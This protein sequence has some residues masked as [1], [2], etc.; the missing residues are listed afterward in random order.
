M[1]KRIGI[2]VVGLNF[3]RHIIEH[4]LRDGPGKPYFDLRA[5]C[6]LDSDQAQMCGRQYGVRAY[7]SIDDMLKDKAIRVVALF[8]GPVGR[9]NQIRKII[10]SGRDVMTTKPFEV[11]PLEALDVLKE[12]QRLGRQVHLNSPGPRY[13]PDIRRIKQWHKDYRLGRPVGARCETWCDYREQADGSWY[14]DSVWCPVAPIF[15]LGIYSI[16]SLVALFGSAQ[17]VTVLHSR[18]FTQRPTPD[19]AVL[20]IRFF[21]GAIATVSASFCVGDGTCYPDTMTINYEKG[22]IY[23]RDVELDASKKGHTNLKLIVNDSP[24]GHVPVIKEEVSFQKPNGA[25]Y[26]WDVL[27]QAIRTGNAT[28]EYSLEDVAAGIAVIQ[29]MARAEQSQQVELVDQIR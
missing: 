19:N 28:G 6:S 29:A 1:L 9:A 17:Y 22:T 7:G 16:N 21:N 27:H 2:G 20:A 13:S 12:A 14:D 5:V 26:Q 23:R 24:S 10:R 3:G 25:H 4:E 11:D 18:L 15:R 8:T